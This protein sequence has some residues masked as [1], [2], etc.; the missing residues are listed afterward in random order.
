MTPGQM[1]AI[2]HEKQTATGEW[3]AA[4]FPHEPSTPAPAQKCL[5]DQ[6]AA[7]EQDVNSAENM[8]DTEDNE[9][10]L[11]KLISITSKSLPKLEV[12][13]RYNITRELGSG[14]YGHVLQVQHR[15]RGTSM[16]LKLM[17]KEHTGRR[18]FLWEY[19]VALCLS[20]HPT[21]LRTIGSAFESSTHYGFAQE[22][23][24]AGDLCSILNS[25]EGLP[26]VQVKRCAAQLADALDFMH[27]KALVHRDIKLDNVL[28]FDQECQQLKLGDF[29]LTRLEGTCIS[30]MSAVLPYSP[31]ELCLLERT[32]SLALDSSLDIWAFGVLLFCICTGCIPWDMA[33]S[34][35]P[36]FEEFSIWQNR[37]IPGEAPG[38]W[39]VFTAPALRMFCRIMALDPNRRSPAIEVNKYLHLPW[40]MGTSEKI[41]DDLLKTISSE[42]CLKGPS[43]DNTELGRNLKENCLQQMQPEVIA[44]EKTHTIQMG[45]NP[46]SNPSPHE[47]SRL[48]G[49]GLEP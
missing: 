26:E 31:P 4:M 36:K 42:A 27:G 13:E 20:S 34:P 44:P 2:V 48:N 37:T 30:A 28:L 1:N 43:E 7:D 16:A 24:P 19:C 47:G 23:A 10:F 41:Q 6:D 17:S 45:P 25:G 14:S 5:P 9:E 11:E 22:L 38:L 18:E 49:P 33:M 35:D 40:R 3:S 12:E 46:G 21:L 29:G 15:E 39:K 8:D 32:E